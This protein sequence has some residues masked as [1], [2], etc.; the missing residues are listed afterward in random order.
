[1]FVIWKSFTSSSGSCKINKE[2]LKNSHSALRSW[3]EQML[4]PYTFAMVSF[5]GKHKI[6]LQNLCILVYTRIYFETRFLMLQ[7]DGETYWYKVYDLRNMFFQ[8][9]KCPKC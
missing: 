5:Q 9:F 7:T 4:G 2:S 8:Q 3:K 6:G 1:M